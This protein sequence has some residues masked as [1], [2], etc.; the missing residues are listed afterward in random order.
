MP[1]VDKI[2]TIEITPERFL[3]A[4][5]PTELAEIDI[6]IQTKY[7]QDKI[8]GRNNQQ[9]K[10]LEL[11]EVPKPKANDEVNPSNEALQ[12]A[13]MVR[14]GYTYEKI[15]EKLYSGERTSTS[16]WREVKQLIRR[17]P[18]IFNLQNY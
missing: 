18:K 13:S 4:C 15:S 17:Y 6:L 9:P 3:I 12:L 8:N 5:S 11:A 10:N 16:I 1:K 14:E 2:L 7:F